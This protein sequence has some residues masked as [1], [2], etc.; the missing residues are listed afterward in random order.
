[1]QKPTVAKLNDTKV[2]LAGSPLKVEVKTVIIEKGSRQGSLNIN[3]E[4]MNA[5]NRYIGK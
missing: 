2:H 3:T 1:M 5:S 4:Q